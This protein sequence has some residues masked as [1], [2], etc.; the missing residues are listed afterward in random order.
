MAKYTNINFNQDTLNRPNIDKLLT[1]VKSLK[2]LG[3]K[4][5]LILGI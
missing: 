3:L 4:I 2:V 5:K 1:K